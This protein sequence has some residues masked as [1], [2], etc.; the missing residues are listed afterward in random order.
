[1]VKRTKFLV[2][3]LLICLI[4]ETLILEERGT[5]GR[6]NVIAFWA[7]D[8][9]VGI[10]PSSCL[11]D[12]SEND[13]SLVLGLGG[14]IVEGRYGNCLDPGVEWNLDLE[15]VKNFALKVSKEAA[16]EFGLVQLKPPEGRT[17]EPL[18]W[19]N[20]RFAAFMTAG[21]NHLRKRIRF[22]NVTETKLNLG[23]F[24][25]TVEFWFKPIR[26]SSENGTVFEI[27]AGPRGENK[28]VTFLKLDRDKRNFIFY[29]YQS[30]DTII[31]KTAIKDNRWQHIAFVYDSNGK[32]IKHYVDGKLIS[33]VSN[34]KILPLPFGKESYMSI[35]RN[36]LWGEPLQGLID[37][38]RF[39]EGVIYRGDFS[40]PSSFSYLWRL[41]ELKN[42][43][44]GPAL[45][46]ERGKESL[47]INLGGRKYLFIDDAIL[48]STGDCK[49]VVNP[50]VKAEI[51]LSNIKGAF[52]KHLTVIEDEQGRVRIY[53]SVEDDRLAVWISDDGINFYE[54]EIQWYKGRKNIVINEPVG[55][56]VVFVDPNAPEEER[57]KYVSNYSDRAVYVY[58]SKD[59]FTFRKYKQPVIP[60]PTGSQV[61]VYY[62]YQKQVYSAFL[63]SDFLRTRTGTTERSY[64]LVETRDIRK[65]WPFKPINF[66]DPRYRDGKS[67]ISLTWFLDNGPLSPPGISAEYPF[68]FTRCEELD[69][70][71][72]DIY[73]AKAHK[74]PWAD[75]VYLAF[76]VVY[77]HYKGSLPLEREILCSPERGLGSGPLETQI[78]V[79][80]DGV[81]WKRYPRPAYVGIGVHKGIDFKTAYIAYGMVRR[82]NEIW[83][84]CFCEPHYHSPWVKFDEKRSVIRLVQQFDRF[85]SLDS[86]YDKETVIVTKPLIFTG[87]KLVLNVDTDATGY[88]QVGFLDENGNKIE[89]YSLDEC[90]YINGDFFEKEVEWIGKGTDVSLLQGKQVKLIF[91]L[92]GAKLYSMQFK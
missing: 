23:D 63:R 76:P 89:G 58:Y 9:P 70:E 72:T 64:V 41:E 6:F 26:K 10:Y 21:E 90:V 43:V 91:K 88:V 33:M 2:L 34:V 62:D 22:P 20:A 24:D 87:N 44:K 77:F 53:T 57:W 12:L 19:Y 27:G 85:V 11:N 56:G 84:Y 79:S 60:I 82:G 39:S 30:K 29:S 50:P 69:P 13:Y 4:T 32:M 28:I 15:D 49:F 51:V 52:R 35:G 71:F 73:I 37:E 8:E 48:E 75:D 36:G 14:M 42:Y 5:G 16:I 46:F 3:C 17:I 78:A 38:M 80:R 18:S 86:P 25:W 65:P 7:F 45:L 55:T 54:P 40:P 61:N 1:M 66:N 81:H 67:K 92:R 31:I 47:P 68:V 59:G 74:Y 83:Q